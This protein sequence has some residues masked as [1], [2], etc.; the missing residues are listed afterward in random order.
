MIAGFIITGALPKKVII[1]GIGP[2]LAGFGIS[3]VLTDPLLELHEPDGS[4]LTNDN[5]KAT[6][7][8][9]IQ[10]TGIAPS[11]DLESAIVVT[12]MPGAYTAILRG[13]NNGMG[14]GLLDVY[15]LDETPT[16]GVANVSIRG[17]VEN[18]D[19]V[20]IAGLITAG[21]EALPVIFCDCDG[22]RG[23]RQRYRKR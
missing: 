6:Q 14:I 23:L 20:L 21:D 4:V 1:R 3:G 12:L 18:G 8:A 7:A 16:L 17:P 5:W 13:V 19:N 10:A 11:N 22:E 9:E 2:S 15:D